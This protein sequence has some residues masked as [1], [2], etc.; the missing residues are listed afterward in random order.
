MTGAGKSEVLKLLIN[1][2]I[3]LNKLEPYCSTV[4]IEPHGDLAEEV[5]KLK[6]NAFSKELIY[7]NPYLNDYF[8]PTINPF[9]LVGEKTNQIIDVTTQ[10]L[11]NVFKE[12]LDTGFSINMEALLY[13]TI[14]TLLNANNITNPI[15]LETL[16]RFMD[17]NNN[18]DLIALGLKSSNQSHREFFKN[19]FN[20]SNLSTSKL[21]LYAKI[22]SL[23]NS[24]IFTKLI[25]GRSTINLEKELNSKKTIIFNLSKGLLG[26]ETS[27]AYGKFIVALINSIVLKRVKQPKDKR[28]PI[29]L[30]IDEAQ[31]YI[32]NSIETTLTELRKY[33]LHLTFAQQILGQDSD[34]QLENIMLSNTNIK[35]T[36]SNSLYTLTKLSNE[37]Q[38][39]LENLQALKTGEFHIKIAKRESF[40]VKVSDKLISNSYMS[41][42]E[43]ELIKRLQLRNYYKPIDE[44]HDT[45]K[46]HKRLDK[47]I[48]NL[49]DSFRTKESSKEEPKSTSKL[50]SFFNATAK[51]YNF[52]K[53]I[54]TD[55]KEDQKE[56]TN[57][58]QKKE[59][60][61]QEQEP[62]QTYEQPQ[63]EPSTNQEQKTE[64]EEQSS[65]QKFKSK[66][67]PPPED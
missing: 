37:T 43:F 57:N 62:Q 23:L 12:I 8:I 61:T 17:D 19:G 32:S 39:P 26:V 50:K 58:G 46:I 56:E 13:P 28:V 36:G 45:R 6:S 38:T 63:E 44:N 49:Y 4:L 51:T 21:A 3:E 41:E 64:K 27:K 67:P 30:Y 40:K 54:Y 34:T 14:A 52:I 31:N 11:V 55:K 9:E 33:G 15:G 59:E 60:A 29:H 16:Q 10:E 53:D 25:T 48:S 42:K 66:Y 20:N 18:K 5:V 47:E 35:I 7:I 1:S 22:Q 65:S 24:H 2:Y